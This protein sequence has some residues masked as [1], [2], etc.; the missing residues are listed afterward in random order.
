M[1]AKDRQ[2]KEIAQEIV[3]HWGSIEQGTKD[4]LLRCSWSET[5]KLLMTYHDKEWGVPVHDDRHL[6]E[7]LC[8]EGAQAGLSWQAI[9]ARRDNYRRAFDSFDA[10]KVARYNDEKRAMLL[11]DEGIIRNRLKVIAFIENAK[12]A[13]AM[14]QEHG[15]LDA[16]LWAFIGNQKLTQATHDQAAAVSQPMSKRL[17]K[18]GFR[19]VGPTIC[20]SFMQ[21]VG[22]MNDHESQCFRYKELEER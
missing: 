19:F 15:S 20:Y 11:Q 10:Q 18:D 4:G 22:M 16:Y 2:P 6:F 14:Q 7:M 13:L 1:D 12:A 21:A 5:N 17:K 3:E 8:L 9:L